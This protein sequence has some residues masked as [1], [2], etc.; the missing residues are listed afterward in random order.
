MGRGAVEWTPPPAL[1]TG[2]ARV[3]DYHHPERMLR[4]IA[5]DDQDVKD[6]PDVGGRSAPTPEDE[7]SDTE[8]PNS[9]RPDDPPG[10]GP[11][12]NAAG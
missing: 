7:A 5:D 8:S 2:Q 12:L 9:S 3:N 11:P 1:D 6:P 10:A 4:G